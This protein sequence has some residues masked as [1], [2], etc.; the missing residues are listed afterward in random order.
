MHNQSGSPRSVLLERMTRRAGP[1]RR[2]LK[3]SLPRS[4]RHAF[5]RLRE[6]NIVAGDGID[7]ATRARIVTEVDDDVRR[8]E[9]IIER[10]LSAWRR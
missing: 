4:A 10:D 1:W 6:N 9:Q 7:T 8:L 2:R 3:R 5:E